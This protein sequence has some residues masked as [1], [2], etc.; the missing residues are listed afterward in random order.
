MLTLLALLLL[1]DRGQDLDRRRGRKAQRRLIKASE[2]LQARDTVQRC[3][4]AKQQVALAEVVGSKVPQELLDGGEAGM[5][6]GNMLA[7]F[8]GRATCPDTGPRAARPSTAA[9]YNTSGAGH[10]Q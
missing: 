7:V 4:L 9:G 1:L 6:L 5:D 3:R 10:G 8:H 2:G